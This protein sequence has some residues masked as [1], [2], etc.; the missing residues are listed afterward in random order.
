MRAMGFTA[1]VIAASID[2]VLRIVRKCTRVKMTGILARRVVAMMENARFVRGRLTV[3]E[4]VAE[5]V[6]YD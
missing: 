5:A 1:L 4:D 6:G 3:I 2:G